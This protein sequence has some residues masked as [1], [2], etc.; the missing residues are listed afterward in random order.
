[1]L[2]IVFTIIGF[3]PIIVKD[4]GGYLV[5]VPGFFAPF[6][7]SS[8][9]CWVVTGILVVVPFIIHPVRNYF[10]NY[11]IRDNNSKIQALMLPL[12]NPLILN[13]RLSKD[14]IISI[15][16]FLPT[17]K[18]SHLKKLDIEQALLLAYVD[19]KGYSN[20]VKDSKFS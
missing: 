2:G 16:E 13:N 12:E 10:R 1:M 20:L 18:L 3:Q 7:Y 11:G 19:L 6:V 5:E 15:A 17:A 14:G 4:R 8:F 9:A